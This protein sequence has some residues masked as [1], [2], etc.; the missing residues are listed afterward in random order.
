[1]RNVSAPRYVLQRFTRVL[2]PPKLRQRRLHRGN[3]AIVRISGL[4]GHFNAFA[5]M[6]RVS[7]R[8]GHN[9]VFN[10]LNTGN[11]KGAATVHVLY[12]LDG[13]ASN[14]NEMTKFSLFARSRRV[15]GGVN[16]VDRGFSLC[17]SLGI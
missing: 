15:G 13:P 6:S 5:T 10:F 17:R 2:Y 16:C 11:T 7:F 12:K 14:D 1:M 3:R 4:Y 8:M 9:R